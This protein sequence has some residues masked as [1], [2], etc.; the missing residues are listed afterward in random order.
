MS[1]VKRLEC[2][3][4]DE[5]LILGE[6][7]LEA[8]L[9]KRKALSESIASTEE[10]IESL[11]DGLNNWSDLTDAARK[12]LGKYHTEDDIIR[13]LSRE[14]MALSILRSEINCVEY[15]I[16]RFRRRENS[17]RGP[18]CIAKE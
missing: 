14:K 15:K 16:E 12:M 3:F 4:R 7:N 10:H 8:A 1:R 2:A 18:T 5:A 17:T 13:T 6:Q 11:Q 9:R